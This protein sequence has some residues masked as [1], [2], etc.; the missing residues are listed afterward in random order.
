M[1]EIFKF[2]LVRT[3]L[4]SFFMFYV[5]Y[6]SQEPQLFYYCSNG[7]FVINVFCLLFGFNIFFLAVLDYVANI[8]S[9]Y[10]KKNTKNRMQI[11]I[12][13]ILLR[14]MGVTLLIFSVSKISI[15]P[16]LYSLILTLYMYQIIFVL[17]SALV[18]IIIFGFIQII[19]KY[20]KKA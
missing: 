13:T 11:L 16:R 1:F 19:R 5:T 17:A 15:R 20:I 14:I 8:I 12:L 3:T 6:L 18:A 10:F 4:F 9:E 2:L 7:I